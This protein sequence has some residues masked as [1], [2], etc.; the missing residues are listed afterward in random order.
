MEKKSWSLFELIIRVFMALMLWLI[1]SAL[2]PLSFLTAGD[3][4]VLR[5]AILLFA[6]G[7]ADREYRGLFNGLILIIMICILY[8]IL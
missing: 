1:I 6:I 2:Q 5:F 8:S 4:R 3:L 7:G